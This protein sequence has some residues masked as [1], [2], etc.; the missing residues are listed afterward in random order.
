MK[1]AILGTLATASAI[2]A[3]A[4]VAG[5]PPSGAKF[6]LWL[7]EVAAKTATAETK[8]D[9]AKSAMTDLKN[10]LAQG[11]PA[12]DQPMPATGD[13]HAH[14][15]M[16]P[17]NAAV[18]TPVI[19]NGLAALNAVASG[20]DQASVL[21]KGQAIAASGK[22]DVVGAFRFHCEPSHLAYADP[23]MYPGDRSGKS[24][25]HLFFGNTKA[26]ADSTYESLRRTGDSSCVNAG[27]RS[28]YWEPA[29]IQ[30][31]AAGRD[32]VVI[33]DTLNIYYKRR[34]AGDP[35]YKA[36]GVTPVN[37]PRGLRY[38]FGAPTQAP[39]F[40]CVD[41]KTWTNIVDWSGDMPG[42]LAKCPVGAQL[43]VS[44]D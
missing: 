25:L 4:L 10:V 12:T 9:D 40:K 32:E 24:H 5:T 23:V 28:G 39:R 1:A 21:L 35:W 36:A 22:P 34:P 27:N 44:V 11:S 26:D 14:H 20:V 16:P 13:P 6:D 41:T 8:L 42:V 7:K 29:M 15:Q 43:D 19:V 2:P 3:V 18:L 17:T 38:I 37:I 33:P 31:N 30:T